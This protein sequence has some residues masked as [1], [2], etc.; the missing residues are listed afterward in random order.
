MAEGLKVIV[1]Y[2]SDHTVPAAHY[3]AALVSDP[4]AAN[5][6]GVMPGL[7]F[8]ITTRLQP[9]LLDQER[10]VFDPQW[11]AQPV[12]LAGADA[13]SLHWLTFNRLRL[14]RAGAW[15]LVVQATDAG[16]FRAIQSVAP[17]LKFAPATGDWLGLT[18]IGKGVSVY[19]LLIGLD[20]VARQILAD[21]TDGPSGVAF[22][23]QV[24]PRHLPEVLP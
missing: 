15:G 19:P 3:M 9:G 7:Q 5:T 22:N 4:Y 6:D 21:D 14:W 2:D 8:P 11:L 13:R 23:A 10:L 17:E 20:G 18:L 1:I 16:Q 24:R 12:F